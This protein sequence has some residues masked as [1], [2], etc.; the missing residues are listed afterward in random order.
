MKE[1]IEPIVEVTLFTEDVV[2]TSN[3]AVK[4][5]AGE[6]DYGFDKLAGGNGGNL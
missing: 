1:Y 5:N 2:R 3:I 4:D 6:T